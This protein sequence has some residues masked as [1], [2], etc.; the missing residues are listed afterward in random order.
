MNNNG[1]C[2]VA[3]K[4]VATPEAANGDR[5]GWSTPSPPL[6]SPALPCPALPFPPSPSPSLSLPPSPSL[7]L[8]PS[9][10]L[11]IPGLP[12]QVPAQRGTASV[13][14]HGPPPKASRTLGAPHTLPR[15]RDPGV[16]APSTPTRVTPGYKSNRRGQR[17][18]STC[19]PEPASVA[20]P[21]STQPQQRSSGSSSCSS[22]S[23]TAQATG[24]WNTPG[25]C[26]GLPSQHTRVRDACTQDSAHPPESQHLRPRP[27]PHS[28]QH[29]RPASHRGQQEVQE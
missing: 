7:P 25:P 11:P 13:E 27:N 10:S 14:E 5:H 26:G 20:I 18:G 3:S 23:T 1:P 4:R 24:A 28:Q 22:G 8:P 15:C 2:I 9:P 16:R 17:T 19:H 12:H 6:P 29:T 21:A